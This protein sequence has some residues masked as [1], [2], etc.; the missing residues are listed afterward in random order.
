MKELKKVETKKLTG[1]QIESGKQQ[2]KNGKYGICV[3]AGGQGS[4][5][6]TKGPKGAVP[7]NILTERRS[8]FEL[9]LKNALEEGVW[10]YVMTSPKNNLQTIEHFTK[11]KSLKKHMNKV[12]FFEQEERQLKNL[13]GTPL[14]IDGEVIFDG[15]GHGS[16]YKS[17]I[18]KG[19][20]KDMEKKGIEMLYVTN[21]DNI[22]STMLDYDFIGEAINTDVSIK[23]VKRQTEGEKVGLFCKKDGNLHVIEYMEVS[24]SLKSKKDEM[25]FYMNWC[26]IMVQILSL[27]FIKKAAK[28]NLPI[29]VANKRKWGRDF[30]KEEFFLFDVFNKAKNY[31]IFEV[32]RNLEF[33]PIKRPEDVDG[34]VLKYLNKKIKEKKLQDIVKKILD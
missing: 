27:D 3:L 11:S 20:I 4:R 5:F 16:L 34:A 21:V 19:I 32:E 15:A 31:K 10:V 13:D 1:S 25:G 12:V 17:M 33:A 2:V 22:C 7:L 28:I 14:E 8:F 18:K 26:N 9:L 30:L 6:Q 23:T 29:H 24:E